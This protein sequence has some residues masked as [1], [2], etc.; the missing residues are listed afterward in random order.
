MD[1]RRFLAELKGRGVYRVS[2]IYAA[3]SW[4]LL[5]VADILFPI[6]GL[7]PWAVSAV[8]AT[9]ALGF[10]IAVVLAWIF[11]ITPEGIV[12]TNATDV[13]FGRL[14]LSPVRL[15]ELGLLV[16]LVC[17]VGFL[18]LDRLASTG[19][20]SSVG[21]L[22]VTTPPSAV[23]DTSRP[24][25]AVLAFDN[26]SSDSEAEYL[27]DGLAEEILN[28]LAKLNELNVAARTSSFYFK[29]KDID[30]REIGRRLGVAHVLEGSVRRS[31]EKVRVT[32]QLI[33]VEDGFHLWSDTYDRDFSDSFL[34]QDEIARDVVASM[35]V[36]LSENSRV[37]L[38]ERPALTPEAY[39]YYLRGL[40]YLR[41]TFSHE[42]MISAAQLFS[43]AIELDENYAEAYAGLCDSYL[44]RYRLDKDPENFQAAQAAC[45]SAISL[46]S[47][48]LPVY[49]AL[50]NL[51][52]LSGKY[53]EA[54]KAFEEALALNP[55]SV[56]AL[57]GVARIQE[58]RH[59][60]EAAE[61]TYL[62]AI[63]V[64]PNY[65]R[66]YLSM[67]S[68]LFASGRF[69]EAIPY[70]TR[71][72]ELMPDNAQA[73]NALGA[74]HYMLGEYAVAAD[75]WERSL[76]LEESALAYSN[77]GSALFF[78][79]RYRDAVD[80]YQ[81]S[82]ELSPEDF[83]SWGNLGDAYRFTD[84]LQ[85]MAEPIYRNAI[86]LAESRL[87][88]NPSDA[89]TLSL[90]AHYYAVVGDKGTARRQ[91]AHAL[92]VA[93]NDINV[94]Y[95]NAVMLTTLK[96]YKGATSALLSAIRLGYTVELIQVDAGLAALREQA[97]Y[98]EMLAEL[99]ANDT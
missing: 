13:D 80:K 73:F 3:G 75:S 64:Q 99:P 21:E 19:D 90:T 15:I 38:E 78:L 60:P 98:T 85:D 71:I 44:N 59:Q 82:V 26:M 70:Y 87:Q 9:A 30:I 7:P 10:P 31:G 14:R 4:A 61:Q 42:T 81:K 25:I 48:A 8:L 40:E 55:N 23:A 16:A 95:N 50:G 52:S 33:K 34:I 86:K 5:Q 69:A 11:D 91:M 65:W 77:A 28:L 74:A 97:V 56:A 94:N 22:S 68:F 88:V 35:Q 37:I 83:E 17:L 92:S 47:D 79:G 18:Y 46:N 96:E 58:R 66:G 39:D 27:G 72:T 54:M 89:I 41:G 32:A 45:E 93:P 12:E 6:V 49:L 63:Q 53:D 57:D 67:G 36:L 24:S 20:A 43:R 76:L 62:R 2:A 29:G 84:D 1:I 51:N